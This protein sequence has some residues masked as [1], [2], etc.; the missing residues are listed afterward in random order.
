MATEIKVARPGVTTW[1][2]WECLKPEVQ[3]KLRVLMP[4]DWEPPTSN[5]RRMKLDCHIEDLEEI[6]RIMRWRPRYL[7]GVSF[8]H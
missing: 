6:D 5:H 2:L 8:P 4:L 1:L 7:K 3:R